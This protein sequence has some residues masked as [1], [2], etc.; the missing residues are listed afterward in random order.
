MSA[1]AGHAFRA[2]IA[3]PFT[4]VTGVLVAVAAAVALLLAPAHGDAA[5]PPEITVAKVGGYCA[6]VVVGWDGA[7][8]ALAPGSRAGE[9]KRVDAA[10]VDHNAAECKPAAVVGAGNRTGR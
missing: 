4:M 2:W 8:W 3:S 10:D 9:P 7:V 5:G 1:R 6:T